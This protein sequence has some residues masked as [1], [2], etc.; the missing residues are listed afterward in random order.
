MLQFG[1]QKY[2]LNEYNHEEYILI[3]T[4]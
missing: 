1:H 3:A 2:L 4:A